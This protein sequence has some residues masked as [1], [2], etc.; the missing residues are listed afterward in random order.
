VWAQWYFAPD[1][2]KN[3]EDDD[4]SRCLD[5]DSKRQHRAARVLYLGMVL[6]KESNHLRYSRETRQFSTI[7]PLEVDELESTTL[8][9]SSMS[10]RSGGYLSSESDYVMV[11]GSSPKQP[12]SLYAQETG[13]LNR[14][15]SKRDN[16]QQTSV[17][18]MKNQSR[19][20]VC[21]GIVDPEEGP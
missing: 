10:P 7:V 1:W 2:F 18:N 20:E 14:V 8:S 11:S 12:P 17:S 6:A 19:A 15:S 13:S 5:D 21:V 9:I 4:G 16:R 3:I